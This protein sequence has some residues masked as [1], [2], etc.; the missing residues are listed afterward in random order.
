MQAM[1]PIG[2]FATIEPDGNKEY[3]AFGFSSAISSANFSSFWTYLPCVQND[4]IS[5]LAPRG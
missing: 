2:N 3:R 5:R 1:K 4:S